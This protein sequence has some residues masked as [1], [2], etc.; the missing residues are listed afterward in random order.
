MLAP[1]SFIPRNTAMP[2][3][4]ATISIIV[5]SILANVFQISI[6]GP[7]DQRAAVNLD[8]DVVVCSTAEWPATFPGAVPSDIEEVA[9]Q[10]GC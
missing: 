6:S 1:E 3:I 2:I 8:P 5:F 9:G 4:P 10:C 7:F